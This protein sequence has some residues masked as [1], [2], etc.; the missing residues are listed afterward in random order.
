[1]NK[2][3]L[4]SILFSLFALSAFSQ[5][6]VD[7][8]TAKFLRDF[9]SQKIKPAHIDTSYWQTS[10]KINFDITAW[11]ISDNWYQSSVRSSLK[12]RFNGVASANYIREY[13]KWNNSMD[14]RL[15]FLWE[16]AGKLTEGAR[17]LVIDNN[18]LRLTTEYAV[19]IAR[20]FDFVA[21]VDLTTQILSSYANNTAKLP[22]KTF[23]APGTVNIGVGAKYSYSKGAIN[24]FTVSL[25]PINSNIT[26][27]LDQRLADLGTSGVKPA[28]YDEEHNLIKHGDWEKTVWGARLDCYLKWF[29]TKDKKLWMDNTFNFFVDYVD[30]FGA[31][32]MNDFFAIYYQFT[33]T[34][35][36]NYKTQL[37][38]Y[39]NEKT[40]VTELINDVPTKVTHGATMQMKNDFT[41]GLTF[42]F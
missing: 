40:V 38:Y 31:G 3:L 26:M 5:T 37:R 19:K 34:F 22:N 25:F 17:N 11:T 4:Y 1:M 13:T 36:V 21:N 20:K 9:D 41:L 32:Q 15:G 30:N 24:K 10:A 28:Q 27:V 12:F 42:N 2:R 39:D 8:N 33:K 14:I 6:V 23:M 18:Y 16:D 29:I 7:E 35:S